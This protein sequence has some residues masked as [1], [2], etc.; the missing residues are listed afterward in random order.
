MIVVLNHP[1]CD[2]NYTPACGMLNSSTRIPAKRYKV[3]CTNRFRVVL[4][5]VDGCKMDGLTSRAETC[6]PRSR[7]KM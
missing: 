1:L 2:S 4:A 3:V 5:E 7:C 6:V